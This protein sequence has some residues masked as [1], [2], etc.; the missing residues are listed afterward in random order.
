MC[1]LVL[2]MHD[3][4][5]S[6]NVDG[7]TKHLIHSPCTPRHRDKNNVRGCSMQIQY[8]N[9][10]LCKDSSDSK[11]LIFSFQDLE[12]RVAG[13]RCGRSASRVTSFCFT[14][15]R[16]VLNL[17]TWNLQSLTHSRVHFHPLITLQAM[18]QYSLLYTLAF[19]PSFLCQLW[20]QI[21]AA[22]QVIDK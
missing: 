3:A 17:W 20:R 6:F 14:I 8:A 9:L 10:K 21:M 2:I 16:S 12:S 4:S 18:Y 19:S 15:L 7:L 11:K 5:N 22:S 13:P 1:V